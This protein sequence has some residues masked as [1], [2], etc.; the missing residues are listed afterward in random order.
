MQKELQALKTNDTWELVNLPSGKHTIGCKWVN[1]VKFKIDM[2][3][4]R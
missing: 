4:K 2:S 3:R 1:K